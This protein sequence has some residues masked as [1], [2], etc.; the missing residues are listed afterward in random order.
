M[1]GAWETFIS[2]IQTLPE[3]LEMTF[4]KV[5]IN[6][7]SN[8]KWMQKTLWY[9]YEG[10]HIAL[11]IKEHIINL[12]KCKTKLVQR[13]H[14]ASLFKTSKKKWGFL[15]S[16]YG[17]LQILLLIFILL[18]NNNLPFQSVKA[19]LSSSPTPATGQNNIL[20]IFT[21]DLNA[22][23][24]PIIG[25]WLAAHIPGLPSVHWIPLYP[26]IASQSFGEGDSSF[27]L[28]TNH[29]SE[30][31]SNFSNFLKQKDIWW[32][33]FIAIDHQGIAT[34][35]EAIGGIDIDDG[36]L[37]KGSAA[38]AAISLTEN[39]Q[40][41]NIAYQTQLIKGFCLQSHKLNELFASQEIF[42]LIPNHIKT[43]LSDQFWEQLS[44]MNGEFACEFPLLEI[45]R[46]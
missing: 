26:T 25:V 16:I 41:K 34:I 29:S 20:L 13:I 32:N 19:L 9:I 4:W 22:T 27:P 1:M 2:N 7:L 28:Y 3:R 6:L 11:K 39:V 46:P 31:P 10:Y 37:T 40:L 5:V 14:Q 33:G 24:S 21:D 42:N 43:N 35:I 44:T 15:L 23:H 12:L 8:S 18:N 38:F 45:S 36:E 30:L 17:L